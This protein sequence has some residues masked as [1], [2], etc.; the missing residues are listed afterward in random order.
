MP[1]LSIVIPVYNKEKYISETLGSVIHQSF[2]DSEIIIV[3]DG[4]TDNSLAVCEA[5]AKKCNR[6]KIFAQENGGA[7]AARNKGIVEASGKYL[8]MVDADDTIEFNA[9]E[10]MV[11]V[12]EKYGCDMVCSGYNYISESA[13]RKRFTYP[14]LQLLEKEYII[15]NIVANSIGIKDDGSSLGEHCCILYSLS[16]IKTNKIV[17]DVLQRKEEDK[18]FILKN[19]YYA[20]SIVFV[21]EYLYNYI[22]RPGSL[23]SKYSPRFNNCLKNLNLYYDLFHSYFDF[24]GEKK[25]N[26]NIAILEECIQY[27]YVHSKEINSV[28]TEIKTMLRKEEVSDWFSHYNGNDRDRIA[29]KEAVKTGDYTKAYKIYKHKFIP[30]RIKIFLY[31]IM[32][33]LGMKK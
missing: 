14:K 6:I 9:H 23:V 31:R 2:T 8:V 13:Q 11:S 25:I 30:Y 16:I 22:Q 4:S 18:P 7:S 26:Y 27:V 21:D 24:Y 12:A 3:D 10:I 5:Y 28:E 33:Q 20:K 15:D 32:S 19:L 1:M 29:V 17:Y